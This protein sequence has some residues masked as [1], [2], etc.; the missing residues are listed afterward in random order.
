M[1]ID[2]FL[3]ECKVA[4]RSESARAVRAGQVLLDGERV[5]RADTKVDPEKN[6]VTYCG[7]VVNYRRNTYVLLNKPEGYVVL[8]KTKRKR[9]CLTFCRKTFVNST[10]FR[11]ADLTKTLLVLCFSQTTD[12]LHIICSRPSIT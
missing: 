2:K 11:V 12:R 8:P 3:S 6:V 7:E 10:F 5:K 4:T 1:R 9:P